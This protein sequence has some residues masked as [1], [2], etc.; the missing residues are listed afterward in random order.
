VATGFIK[1]KH[2]RI[3][4]TSTAYACSES[5]NELPCCIFCFWVKLNL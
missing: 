3:N 4:A 2:R 1:Q 5:T